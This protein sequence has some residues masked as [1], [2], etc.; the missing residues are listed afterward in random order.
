M[1][2]LSRKIAALLAGGACGAATG[3]GAGGAATYAT[4]VGVARFGTASTGA[5][6]FVL[7][8][9]AA[10][11]ATLARLGGGTL[12]TGGGGGAAGTLVLTSIVAAPILI[13]FAGCPY[14]AHRRN[15]GQEAELTAQ[16]D[17]AE[18]SLDSTQHGFDLLVE[19][20][21]RATEALEYIGVHAAH[22]LEKWEQ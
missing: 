16:L 13:L 9:P 6:I 15:K 3:S 8:G 18:E 7:F 2:F 19:T 14:L 11:N 5:P 17:V 22:A 1:S 21:T 20:L 12:A 4:F 10:T